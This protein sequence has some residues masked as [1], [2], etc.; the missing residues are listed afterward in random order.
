M[1]SDRPSALRRRLLA[2]HHF[3]RHE[4]PSAAIGHHLKML[5]RGPSL[6]PL[7]HRAAF[8]RLKRRSA[9]KVDGATPTIN[10]SFRFAA[11]AAKGTKVG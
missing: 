4:R 10:G 11:D 3:D 7:V 9:D 1:G 2:T 6:Q 5:Q 8:C